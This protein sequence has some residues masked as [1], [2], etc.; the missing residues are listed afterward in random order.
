MRMSTGNSRKNARGPP[1]FGGDSPD[2]V[3]GQ[4]SCRGWSCADA[5]SKDVAAG[6]VSRGPAITGPASDF[7]LDGLRDFDG[8]GGLTRLNACFGTRPFH[9]GGAFHFGDGNLVVRPL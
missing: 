5:S 6:S 9:P 7:L 4:S 3:A 1:C 2:G 8:L